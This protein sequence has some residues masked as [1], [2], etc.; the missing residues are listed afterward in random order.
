MDKTIT[1]A[2]EGVV[3]ERRKGKGFCNLYLVNEDLAISIANHW[4]R[5]RRIGEPQAET[6]VASFR[7]SHQLGYK[8]KGGFR[9][10]EG[11]VRWAIKTAKAAQPLPDPAHTAELRVQSRKMTEA[12]DA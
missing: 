9:T 11:A 7:K 2:V 5:Q 8:T 4:G 3:F 12:H 10:L 1:R 6:F